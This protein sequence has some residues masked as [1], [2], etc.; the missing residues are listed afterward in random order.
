MIIHYLNSKGEAWQ[1]KRAHNSEKIFLGYSKQRKAMTFFRPWGNHFR[2]CVQGTR[3]IGV[4]DSDVT[5][6][7]AI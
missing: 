5:T 3:P 7:E 1:L 4:N 2:Y 6:W